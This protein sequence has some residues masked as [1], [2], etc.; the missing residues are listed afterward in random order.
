M[1]K[2]QFTISE[3]NRIT[4]K[5]RTT[6][7]KHI[8][9]GKLSAT[10]NEDDQKLVEAAELIRVYGDECDFGKASPGALKVPSSPK[11]VASGGGDHLQEALEKEREERARERRHFEDQIENLQDSLKTAQEGH[12]RATLLLENHSS[13]GGA[14]KE[15]L[16]K[17]A[18]RVDR[19]E[20][21]LQEE[22]ELTLRLKRQ[23]L[24]LKKAVIAERQKSV[25]EKLFG[26]SRAPGKAP[27]TV[28]P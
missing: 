16:D 20:L 17:L 21:T 15:A 5:S 13:G 7:T 25:W 11:P 27:R 12:N 18:Q 9:Q 10:Q 19:Q 22:K 23:N 4:G 26:T 24:R 1:S 14:L 8:K 3:I 2:S 6:I 28:S